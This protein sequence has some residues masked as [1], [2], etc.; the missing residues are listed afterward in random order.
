MWFCPGLQSRRRLLLLLPKTSYR[1]GAYLHAGASLGVEV[2]VG[3]NHHSVLGETEHFLSLPFTR[4]GHAVEVISRRAQETPF[5]GILGTDEASSLIAAMAGNVGVQ[6]SGIIVQGLANNSLHGS[7]G[8]RLVKEIGTSVL[9]GIALAI[10][11]VIFGIALNY[12]PSF[13]ITIAGSLVVVILIAALIG[14]SIPL[15]L[16]KWGIDPALAT[17][18]FITTSNDIFGIFI[19]FYLAK[20]I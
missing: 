15:V 8:K 16:D 9:N 14:T 18:P 2:V 19:F 6:S 11:V 10:L 17:G 13:Y 5:D 20:L 3:S 1:A 12:D 4:P 7:I